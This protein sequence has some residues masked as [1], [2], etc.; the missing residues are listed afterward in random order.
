[1]KALFATL[2]TALLGAPAMAAGPDTAALFEH[3]LPRL[4]SDDTLDMRQFAG[5]PLLVVNTA[6]HCGFTGQFEGLEA[7]HQQYKEQGLRVVGF[8]SDDFKQEAKSEAEAAEM[9][10]VNYGVTFDMAAPVSVK[11][12]SAHPIFKEITRQTGKQPRWNFY[13]YV[14]D[15]DG[16][17]T[18]VFSS[19]TGPESKRLKAAI[20]GVL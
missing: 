5:Q 4:H 10:F 18:E 17:V 2:C 6:S 11:G 16:R 1:M 19:I 7:L 15:R 9:C 3:Q 12:D 8:P 14:I 13:K 20:E